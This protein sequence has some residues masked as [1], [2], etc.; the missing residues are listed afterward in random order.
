MKKIAAALALTLGLASL[1]SANSLDFSY[2]FSD[3]TDLTGTLLGN[4]ESNGNTFDVTG[5]STASWNGTT[6]TGIGTSNI[7]SVL[8]FPSFGDQ[9]TVSID[10]GVAGMNL[11]VCPHG[12]TDGGYNCIF[13]SDP[14]FFLGGGS[15]AGDSLGHSVF[16]GYDAANW[17]ASLSAVPEGSTWAMLALGVLV[18]RLGKGSRRA[19]AA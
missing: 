12:F 18:L 15:G 5:V 13:G 14:G 16:D 9:P 19:R 11:F 10:G 3:G 4:L 6:W 8:G 2:H 1:A 7:H 17:H